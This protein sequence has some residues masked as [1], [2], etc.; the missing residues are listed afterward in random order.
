MSFSE[1]EMSHA[2]HRLFS[3]FVTRPQSRAQVDAVATEL[4]ASPAQVTAF[5]DWHTGFDE[6]EP[7]LWQ[8]KTE[9]GW[10]ICNSLVAGSLR[11]QPEHLSGWQHLWD[12]MESAQFQPVTFFDWLYN[13]GLILSLDAEVFEEIEAQRETA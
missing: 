8:M 4:G 6:V 13:S 3:Y 11:M 5:L 7:G 9:T 1:R 10:K 12:L 2:A